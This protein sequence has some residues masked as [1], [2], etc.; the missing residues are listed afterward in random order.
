VRCPVTGYGLNRKWG[1]TDLRFDLEWTGTFENIASEWS[2]M[3]PAL[4]DRF[5]TAG[6]AACSDEGSLAQT[7]RIETRAERS[8]VTFRNWID[9]SADEMNLAALFPPLIRTATGEGNGSFVI[10]AQVVLEERRAE[11]VRG[12]IKK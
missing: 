8:I 11:Y 4:T 2:L 10:S 5:R 1:P 12:A 6:R 9:T 7:C 3:S